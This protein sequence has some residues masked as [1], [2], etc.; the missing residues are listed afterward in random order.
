MGNSEN[1][2]PCLGSDETI[3][4]ETIAVWTN[5]IT[6]GPPGEYLHPL[7]K[8]RGNI[9]IVTTIEMQGVARRISNGYPLNP[10]V[11]GACQCTLCNNLKNHVEFS[12]LIEIGL[13]V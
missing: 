11:H 9:K 13:K 12:P 1:S 2:F 5:T 4:N 3:F 6:I 10:C 8:G 7:D